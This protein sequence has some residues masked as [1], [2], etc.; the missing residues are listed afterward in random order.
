MRS[1]ESTLWKRIISTNASCQCNWVDTC[2]CCCCC[3]QAQRR[4]VVAMHCHCSCVPSHCLQSTHCCA[5]IATWNDVAMTH[6]ASNDRT[7][8]ARHRHRALSLSCTMPTKMNVVD[9]IDAVAMLRCSIWIGVKK[10]WCRPGARIDC[11]VAVGLL[12]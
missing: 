1:C 3:C 5:R 9:S 7:G 8:G 6:V 2:C 4:V 10:H 11:I 12:S